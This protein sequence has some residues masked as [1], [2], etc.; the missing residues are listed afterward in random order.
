MD[1]SIIKYKVSEDDT[2]ALSLKEIESVVVD[3]NKNPER[4]YSYYHEER[5]IAGYDEY[6][7][8]IYS[9]ENALQMDKE[10]GDK[11]YNRLSDEEIHID[12]KHFDVT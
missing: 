10:T 2:G 5:Q 7:S 3:G 1:F 9:S 11:Y 6:G 12:L 4:P 8:P